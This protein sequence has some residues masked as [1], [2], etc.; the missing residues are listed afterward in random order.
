MRYI[1][2]LLLL[3]FFLYAAEPTFVLDKTKYETV[4]VSPLLHTDYTTLLPYRYS[5]RP[6]CSS[7][8][9]KVLPNSLQPFV[10]SCLALDIVS[11][12]DTDSSSKNKRGKS[13]FSSQFL[14]QIVIDNSIGQETFSMVDVLH[15]LEQKGTLKQTEWISSTKVS[16]KEKITPNTLYKIKAFQRLSNTT[17]DRFVIDCFR[18]KLATQSPILAVLQLPTAMKDNIPV[19]D[20]WEAKE[21]KDT[22]LH[23][24]VIV[25]Y[26]DA[27]HQFEILNTWGNSWGDQGFAYV[28]YS[29]L[30]CYL[31]ESYCLVGSTSATAD[32]QNI[33]ATLLF[34]ELE[35]QW[36]ANE[37]QC[38]G[39]PLR[40]MTALEQ[41]GIYKMLT[42]NYEGVNY[43]IQVRLPDP[44]MFVYVL[45]VDETENITLLYPFAANNT[46]TVHSSATGLFSEQPLNIIIPHPSYCLQLDNHIGTHNIALFA[47][48]PIDIN[49]LLRNWTSLKGST[50]WEKLQES[51][52]DRLAKQDVIEYAVTNIGFSANVAPHQ[53]AALVVDMHHI[54][55]LPNKVSSGF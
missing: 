9:T 29:T 35:Q 34:Q 15:G 23:S 3:P 40:T 37:Y 48:N 44:A 47:T 50:V 30:L 32:T 42:A 43:Q 26:D 1:F 14:Q 2:F 31:K 53:I 8:S 51:L 28:E 16:A 36:V 46:A 22:F 38:N 24:L 45:S 19:T 27:R 13:G 21:S 4:S 55:L 49:T 52:P 39:K 17:I 54:S 18:E 5:L 25:G 20:V 33:A 11:K 41:D 10:A 7:V 12:F 6:Y